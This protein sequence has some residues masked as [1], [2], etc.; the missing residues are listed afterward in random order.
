LSF[1]III[2]ENSEYFSVKLCT[3]GIWGFT[4]LHG[5]DTENQRVRKMLWV[6]RLFIF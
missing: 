2:S 4:A 5:E 1:E 3:T 6:F